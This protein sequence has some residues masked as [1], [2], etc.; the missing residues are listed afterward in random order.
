MEIDGHPTQDLVDE[1]VRRRAMQAAGTSAGPN[2]EALR[3]IAD[4]HDDAQGLWI[5]LP[6]Q[7]FLTGVDD[8]PTG[9]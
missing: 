8:I 3:F 2:L 9:L 7:A 5:F 4:R 6:S 1:L